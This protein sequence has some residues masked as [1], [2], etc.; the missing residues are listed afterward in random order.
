VRYGDP[1]RHIRRAAR[2][3][4]DGSSA[5]S[6]LQIRREPVG[7]T[8]GATRG[9]TRWY[10]MHEIRCGASGTESGYTNGIVKTANS[11]GESQ[12]A[13]RH[14]LTRRSLGSK[15]LSG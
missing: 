10:A 4:A 15:K 13:P 2:V 5:R 12:I 14:S 9:K 7:F 11:I 3:W 8:I 1:S 6:C